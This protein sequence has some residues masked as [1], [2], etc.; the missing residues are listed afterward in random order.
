MTLP[1]STIYAFPPNQH[2][3][4]YKEGVFLIILVAL[5]ALAMLVALITLVALAV[6]VALIALIWAVVLNGVVTA[7]MQP[8]LATPGKLRSAGG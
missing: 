3:F 1:L 6:L 5:V 2:D 7:D 4:P 8:R